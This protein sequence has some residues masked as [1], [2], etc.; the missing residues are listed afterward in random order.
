[1]T[2]TCQA[3]KCVADVCH[4]VAYGIDGQHM[5]S[6]KPVR[7]HAVNKQAEGVLPNISIQIL[8]PNKLPC[9]AQ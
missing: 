5:L 2:A 6:H 8:A 1:M 7:S 4:D 3:P 9:T